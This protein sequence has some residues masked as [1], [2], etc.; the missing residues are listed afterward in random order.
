M[1]TL[2][3]GSTLPSGT[4][5]YWFFG[6]VTATGNVTPGGTTITGLDPVALATL[7]QVGP[8][9]NLVVNGLGIST[10][11]PTKVLSID[12]NGTITLDTPLDQNLTAG[13]YAYTI[14]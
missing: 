12:P 2:T 13:H 3:P 6:P 9:T 1:V 14:T 7:K 4:T 8:V 5:T 11:K 10:T